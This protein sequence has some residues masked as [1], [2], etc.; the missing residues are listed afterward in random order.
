MQVNSKNYSLH[1][2]K[3]PQF[4]RIFVTQNA[5]PILK[6]Y[7]KPTE[8]LEFSK[9][10]EGQ[11]QNPIEISL[12]GHPRNV[13]LDELNANI[14]LRSNFVPDV[15]VPRKSQYVGC[16]RKRFESAIKFLRRCCKIAD[17]MHENVVDLSKINANK[18]LENAK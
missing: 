6:K 12:F 1:S 8:W 17:K 13:T 2:G 16:E 10:I 18:I 15:Y 3:N 7:L 5:E 11:K 4:G 14:Y 9:M